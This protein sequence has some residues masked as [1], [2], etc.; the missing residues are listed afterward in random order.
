MIRYR[1]WDE[2]E[3]VWHDGLAVPSSEMLVLGRER[4]LWVGENLGQTIWVRGTAELEATLVRPR[5]G[6]EIVC[7]DWGSALVTVIGGE[8][9]IRCIDQ[10]TVR[11]RAVGTR[12]SVHVGEQAVARVILG[13]SATVDGCGRI[14]VVHD[15][16]GAQ[17]C[18]RDGGGR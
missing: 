14:L 3:V 12:L 2:K 5:T 16:L 4:A 15:H 8:L 7:K 11:V 17:W 13:D 10:A 6:G 9:V 1:G 18:V